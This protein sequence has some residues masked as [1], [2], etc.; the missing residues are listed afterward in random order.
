MV[1]KRVKLND[2]IYKIKYKKYQW[3]EI[4]A[5][6]RKCTQLKRFLTNDRQSRENTNTWLNGWDGASTN[7]HGNHN[8]ILSLSPKWSSN[9]TKNF[10]LNKNFTQITKK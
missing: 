10:K 3:E 5:K 4:K 1:L 2:A 7:L 6:M 9:S 8:P